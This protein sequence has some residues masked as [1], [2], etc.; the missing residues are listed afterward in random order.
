MKAILVIVLAAVLFLVGT[1]VS[2]ETGQEAL[3]GDAMPSTFVAAPRA[4]RITGAAAT[5]HNL[6][7]SRP[8]VRD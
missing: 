6:D 1:P 7:E 4:E 3:N 5:I 8:E 2:A